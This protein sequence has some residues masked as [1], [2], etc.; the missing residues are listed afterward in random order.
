MSPGITGDR[1]SGVQKALRERALICYLGCVRNFPS[2]TYLANKGGRGIGG[3][4]GTGLLF[5]GCTVSTVPISMRTSLGVPVPFRA[6][7]GATSE[8]SSKAIIAKPSDCFMFSSEFPGFQRPP[9]SEALHRGR[10]VVDC[11]ETVR[12]NFRRCPHRSRLLSC[13]SRTTIWEGALAIFCNQEPVHFMVR[14]NVR[15]E[16]DCLKRQGMA[17]LQI[18]DFNMVGL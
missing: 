17:A 18:L 2:H 4:C 11:A 5:L 6:H 10:L 12:G 13:K 8:V 9:G 1:D 7:K 16:A 15:R 3:G 14:T